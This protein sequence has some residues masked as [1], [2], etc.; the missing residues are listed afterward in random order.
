[1]V[2]SPRFIQISTYSMKDFTLSKIFI[3]IYNLTLCFFSIKKL[4]FLEKIFF[5]F[6]ALPS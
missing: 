2:R 5:K 1:M 3:K 4:Y 6:I